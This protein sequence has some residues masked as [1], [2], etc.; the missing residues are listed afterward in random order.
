MTH[1]NLVV[2]LTNLVLLPLVPSL[3]VAQISGSRGGI[4]HDGLGGQNTHGL[5]TLAPEVAAAYIT[6]DGQAEVRVKPTEIRVV[7]AVTAEGETP[8]QCTRSVKETIKNL[9]SQWGR[10]GIS[11]QSI[12]ED[13]IAIL[14]RY[15]F[16]IKKPRDQEVAVEKKAGYLMQ[17]NLHVAVKDD[18]SAMSAI[19][20]AFE[21]GVSDIIA[22]DYWSKELDEIKIKAR[23]EALK[24]AKAKSDKLF[25][26][27]FD[28]QPPVINLQ[29]STRVIYPESLYES[30]VND[31]SAEYQ[32]TYSRRDVPQI[33][34][35]RPK[36]TY[37]R[38]LYLDGDVQSKELPMRSEI[39]VVSTVRLY[40]LSPAAKEFWSATKKSDTAPTR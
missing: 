16:E 12:V 20:I 32:A 2:V 7:L 3:A 4:T 26:E 36:N 15:E 17:T 10:S 29:E 13:F 14:P 19:E 18:A 30:F 34:T 25:G 37:Y 31:S 5:A 38:G 21:H 23:S 35:F 39:S 27:L 22:L 8:A 9:T 11:K 24:A 28:S 6:I 40:F 33:R 1:F